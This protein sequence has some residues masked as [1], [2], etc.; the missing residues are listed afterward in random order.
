MSMDSIIDFVTSGDISE[1]SELSS[2]EESD[3][4][5]QI[6]INIQREEELE[7]AHDDD[8]D[9]DEDDI[10]LAQLATDPTPNNDTTPPSNQ[11]YTYRWRKKDRPISK[12]QF[13]GQFSDPPI[14]DMTPKV[15]KYQNLFH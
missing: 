8:R 6:M 3:D 14:D 9:Y 15:L 11:P 5:R 4:E 13:L 12:N 1:L 7:S 2:D 10:P